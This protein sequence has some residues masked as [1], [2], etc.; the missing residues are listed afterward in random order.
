MIIDRYTKI[1]LT[2]I[3]VSLAVMA[4]SNLKGTMIKPAMASLDCG[5]YLDPCYVKI[6]GTVTVTEF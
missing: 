2:V 5:G 3:A 6:K 1:I 4:F